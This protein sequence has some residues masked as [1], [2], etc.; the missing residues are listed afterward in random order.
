MIAMGS[1][2]F[3]RF[4]VCT[5]DGLAFRDAP[6]DHNIHINGADWGLVS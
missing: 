4:L 5:R 3:D 1:E 2:I 6:A